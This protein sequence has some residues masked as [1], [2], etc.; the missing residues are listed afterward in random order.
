MQP[1]KN[2]RMLY[3]ITMAHQDLALPPQ[4]LEVRE[5]RILVNQVLDSLSNVL[6]EVPHREINILM[7]VLK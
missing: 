1:W 2:I 3:S 7:E 6:H 5:D 4:N